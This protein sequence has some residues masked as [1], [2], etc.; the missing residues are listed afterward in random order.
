MQ[1]RKEETPAAALDMRVADGKILKPSAAQLAWLKRGLTQPGGKLPI[2]DT[3]GKRVSD[4]TIKCC[5]ENGWAKPWFENP[6]KPDW[7]VCK[8]TSSGQDL[9]SNK[10]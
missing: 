1:K 9:L 5:I 4:R 2:F 6:V 3:F 7:Q 8:L 10:S